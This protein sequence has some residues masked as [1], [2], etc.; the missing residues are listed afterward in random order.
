M[1]AGA[2]EPRIGKSDEGPPA[3]VAGVNSSWAPEGYV[4]AAG[5]LLSGTGPRG[6]RQRPVC[7]TKLPRSNSSKAALSSSRVFYQLPP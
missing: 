3:A 4:A 2:A 5:L 6:R 7:F 1:E